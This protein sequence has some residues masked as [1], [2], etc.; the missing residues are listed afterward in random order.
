MQTS[1]NSDC[2]L[3]LFADDSAISYAHKSPQVISDKISQA[4]DNCSE[5]LIDNKLSLHPGKTDSSLFF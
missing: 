3:V 5:W 4:L 1:L 2:K